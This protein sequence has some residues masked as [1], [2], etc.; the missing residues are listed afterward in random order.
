[1]IVSLTSWTRRLRPTNLLEKKIVIG[2]YKKYSDGAKEMAQSICCLSMRM[3]GDIQQPHAKLGM[4]GLGVGREWRVNRACL[5]VQWESL[6]QVTSERS[7]DP[8]FS[9]A[10]ILEHTKT[11]KQMN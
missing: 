6:S 11:N 9:M 10:S 4:V 2:E 5:Q 7:R 3:W 8:T 1:M